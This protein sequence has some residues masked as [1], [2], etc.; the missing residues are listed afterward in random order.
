MR[1]LLAQFRYGAA[2]VLLALRDRSLEWV[3]VGDTE[4][5][6][7]DDLVIGTRGRVDGLQVKW[8]LDPAPYTFNRLHQSVDGP[9]QW[10]ELADGWRT[11]RTAHAQRRV[12]VHLI[13]NDVPSTADNAMV[14]TPG[15]TTRGSFAAFLR[16]AWAPAVAAAHASES[17]WDASDSGP[18]SS[19]RDAKIVRALADIRAA[20]PLDWHGTYEKL[21]ALSG[22][23]NA[24]W[25]E[26]LTGCYLTIP[27]SDPLTLASAW[28]DRTAQQ[29]Q[30]D[31]EAIATV[32]MRAVGDRSERV[33][34]S[35]DALLAELGWNA[36]VELFHRHEF[37]APTGA[38]QPIAGTVDALTRTLSTTASGYLA[39]LGTP[40][41]GKST[42]L[43]ETLR[44]RERVIRYYAYVPPIVGTNMQ[45]GEA[46]H[47][48][49]D[50]VVALE[51]QGIAPSRTLVP[52][53]ASA[54]RKAWT[55]QLIALGEEYQRT[56]RKTILVLDGLDH[57]QR[58]QQPTR[59]LLTELPPPAALPA[60][61]VIVL[62]SQT[63]GLAQLPSAVRAQLREDG[64]VLH[65]EPL[66]PDDVA[67]MVLSALDVSLDDDDAA[68]MFRLSGGHPLAVNYL[69]NRLRHRP[70]TQSVADALEE[71]GQ[72]STL[73]SEQY[74]EHWGQVRNDFALVRLLALLARTRHGFRPG[75]V[76]S[77]ADPQAWHALTQQFGH[78]FRRD[79]D[80]WQFFHNSF[81]VFL[82]VETRTVE[83]LPPEEELFLAL[84]AACADAP[85]GLHS[86]RTDELF[87]RAQA[88]DVEHV[89]RLA[90]LDDWRAQFFAGRAVATIRDDIR[91]ALLAALNLRD[92][93]AMLRFL[94]AGA[95]FRAREH[96]TDFLNLGELTARLGD[97]AAAVEWVLADHVLLVDPSNALAAAAALHK[98]GAQ[99]AAL[100]VFALAEPLRWIAG[101]TPIP[102][103]DVS[104]VYSDLAAWAKVAPTFRNPDAVAEAISRLRVER[105]LRRWAS[106]GAAE[107]DASAVL[108]AETAHAANAQDQ[109]AVRQIDEDTTAEI[110]HGLLLVAAR[111][112]DARERFADVDALVAA[113]RVHALLDIKLT[114]DDLCGLW[115]ELA[116][117]LADA[118]PDVAK[119]RLAM[120]E[121]F[122]CTNDEHVFRVAELRMRLHGDA[123]YALALFSLVPS[124]PV[125]SP[126]DVAS[127]ED[128]LR[129]F[130]PF[131]RHFRLAYAVGVSVDVSHVVGD[132]DLDESPLLREFHRALLILARLAGSVWAG[133]VLSAGSVA[134]ALTGVLRILGEERNKAGYEPGAYRVT[135]AREET[136]KLLVRIAAANGPEVR[137]RAFTA[138][139]QEWTRPDTDWPVALQRSVLHAFVK[140][141]ASGPL[142]IAAVRRTEL[143]AF[144]AGQL[145]TELA[146]AAE[147]ARLWLSLG[148][149]TR[150]RAT[151]AH[152]LRATLSVE[153]KD[154]QL[155]D[156]LEWSADASDV[157]P[158]DAPRR[159]AA[160]AMAIK[161]SDGTSE[162][163]RAAAALLRRSAA[164]D[165]PVG[166]ALLF[167]CLSHGLLEWTDAWYAF[168]SGAMTSHGGSAPTA[169]IIFAHLLLPV[170]GQVPR[171]WLRTLAG[172]LARDV[173]SPLAQRATASVRVALERELPASE[174]TS[175]LQAFGGDEESDVINRSSGSPSKAD[176]S[177]LTDDA[178]A[179]ALHSLDSVS[180]VTV[181]LGALQSDWYRV[182]WVPALTTLISRLSS[183]DLHALHAS[184]P[185]HRRF[186]DARIHLARVLAAR[187]DTI[188]ARAILAQVLGDSDPEEWDTTRSSGTRLS[189]LEALAHIDPEEARDEAWRLLAADLHAGRV[190]SFG[191]ARAWRR[192]APVLV[193]MVPLIALADE[194]EAHVNVLSAHAGTITPPILPP[195]SRNPQEAA[196][197]ALLEAVADLLDHPVN[198]LNQGAVRV[199][200]T[201]LVWDSN[202]TASVIDARLA[203]QSGARSSA[204]LLVLE[205]VA[206]VDLDRV[207]TFAPM[208]RI[209]RD[210]QDFRA[211]GR[212]RALLA[213]LEGED[214]NI[215]PAPTVRPALP[216]AYR[217]LQSEALPAREIVPRGRGGLLPAAMSATE[218]TAAFRDLV[219]MAA[220]LA[221]V[222]SDALARD[223]VTRVSSWGAAA[224]SDEEEVLRQHLSTIGLRLP[225]RR[226]R[227][228]VVERAL[229][230]SLSILE[231]CGRFDAAAIAELSVE[232]ED[233]DVAF[234][235]KLPSYRPA[236]VLP[237]AE[238]RVRDDTDRSWYPHDGWT[239]RATIDD[240][241]DGN[242]ELDSALVVLGEI[243]IIRWA[244]HSDAIEVRSRTRQLRTAAPL[245]RGRRRVERPFDRDDRSDPW[246]TTLRMLKSWAAQYRQALVDDY[247]A[248]PPVNAL[249]LTN[250]TARFLIPG[251]GWIAINPHLAQELG[252]QSAEDG[253]FRWL[254]PD[255]R[256]MAES[257]WWQDG[258]P[259]ISRHAG[260][261]EVATGWQVVVH[262]DAWRAI[263]GHVGQ[264]VEWRHV[265]RAAHAQVTVG[266]FEISDCDDK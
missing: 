261:D 14:A 160:A 76:R 94:L 109:T 143:L 112:L 130:V 148:D 162:S 237:L 3:R 221:R 149:G 256:I 67:A 209:A 111:A 22:L 220:A 159:L 51:Q 199:L 177:H 153:E 41:S 32:L 245:L 135:G 231:D 46:L 161:A 122:G 79:T 30:E 225:F 239:A 31:V 39:V 216:A 88:G 56:G 132:R 136:M 236:S 260:D 95:E 114:S 128:G 173:S 34:W 157:V 246:Y 138:C 240:F 142:I 259:W 4:A 113:Y 26:F 145:E 91:L 232:L 251:D 151:I 75:W 17:T 47:F 265:Q 57:I 158:A 27:A 37:P 127:S 121:A 233:A 255:G 48:L 154:S 125:V 195:I 178:L 205:A 140:A 61:V 229:L 38:Y 106:L 105:D 12:T 223:V 15:M 89:I 163:S 150:A 129:G 33:E 87:Y 212:I 211:R 258:S 207:A 59:S 13:T 242:S 6:G 243:S 137:D 8:S 166:R 68:E 214:D 81:R 43:T 97:P 73:V 58:E 10:A 49:H 171:G 184:L 141:G 134:S 189:A 198:A 100:E 248:L 200:A 238:R 192:L 170:H 115:L 93:T 7:V 252:W 183:A 202:A 124:A 155:I 197:E 23:S 63:L 210:V 144:T 168:L 98:A 40:G 50:V 244:G 118:A 174:R 20:V 2:R 44:Y 107:E 92:A 262:P 85:A 69:I 191:L 123:A 24:E 167:W 82:L 65:M 222:T 235:L 182:E 1:G 190:G 84:A 86:E 80:R 215:V 201:S 224:T 263:V 164:L 228:Q 249:L 54:L 53:D 227:Q 247:D 99:L 103:H 169:A 60:G 146:E 165:V 16:E 194:V 156:W 176:G 70:D 179:T 64:R 172:A 36:R 257:L 241:G 77:W 119:Q 25:P 253:W 133:T 131:F 188:G 108:D 35:R 193:D 266:E 217:V 186:S 196:N 90:R 55:A 78:Y 19:E 234:V 29:F 218:V 83:A 250:W 175:A 71:A 101:P 52:H 74:L 62:G 264:C 180:D 230:E 213:D 96:Y 185:H 203:A 66:R 147:Q 206:L 187:E 11:L 254:S 18:A 208:L 120:A 9:S 21:R 5:G 110:Q 116:W 28:G 126:R 181:L 204:L 219:E 226:P 104:E 72:Y 152:A 117:N 102:A 139:E 45:R 42:L